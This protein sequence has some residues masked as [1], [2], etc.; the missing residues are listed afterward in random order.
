MSIRG[1]RVGSLIMVGGN[2][3]QE[4]LSANVDILNLYQ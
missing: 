1:K 2:G 4:T 3:I